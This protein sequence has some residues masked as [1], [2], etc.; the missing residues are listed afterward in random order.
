MFS[1]PCTRRLSITNGGTVQP[2]NPAIR[3]TG[4]WS[5]GRMF[6]TLCSTPQRSSINRTASTE[7]ECTTP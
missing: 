7:W 3:T 2:G 4:A 5:P 6:Q 1:V